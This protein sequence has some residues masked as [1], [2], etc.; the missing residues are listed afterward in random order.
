MKLYIDTDLDKISDHTLE[1]L[2]RFSGKKFTYDELIR[3]VKNRRFKNKLSNLL[4]EYD[5]LYFGEIIFENLGNGKWKIIDKTP[6]VYRHIIHIVNK[7]PWPIGDIVD[8]RAEKLIETVLS[9]DSEI[10]QRELEITDYEYSDDDMNYFKDKIEKKY[11]HE[12]KI[13]FDLIYDLL[14]IIDECI[15]DL[16][17]R[18]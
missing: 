16:Y 7:L 15:G 10:M 8:I 5:K 11:G 12:L 9:I 3:L 6:N 14:V 4:D 2:K 17:F 13:S 18:E 1:R